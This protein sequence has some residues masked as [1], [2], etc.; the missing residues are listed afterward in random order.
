M[1]TNALVTETARPKEPSL[2]EREA[3]N[4]AKEAGSLGISD[5]GV[6]INIMYVLTTIKPTITTKEYNWGFLKQE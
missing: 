4:S 6:R 1:A 3:A 5:Q 2:P